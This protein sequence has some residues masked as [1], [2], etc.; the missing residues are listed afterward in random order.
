MA[1]LGNSIKHSFEK[2]T[3]SSTALG[4]LMSTFTTVAPMFFII[5]GI[6]F[7]YRIL[8][9]SS[10]IYSQRVLFSCSIL[11][12]FI[13]SLL[14]TAP[15]N[16]VISRY[17]T[18]RIFEE[19]YD[20]ILP[21]FYGGLFLNLTV[22]CLFGIP[23]GLLIGWNKRC[24][25]FLKPIFELIRPVPALAWIPLMT[26]WFGIGESSKIALIFIGTLMPVVVNTYSGVRLIPRLNIDVARAFG[27][28]EFQIVKEIVL[29]CSLSAIMAGVKTAMGTAWI[30]VL[31]AEMI[32]ANSGLGFMII[33]GSDV[34]DL[35][36]VILAMIII[37]VIGAVLSWLLTLAERKLCPWKEEIN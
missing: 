20:A 23:F 32:S 24:C 27:A 18:D 26:L 31:A 4:V 12:I 13:F 36:L 1:S 6:L 3:I 28:T 8:D 34:A 33:R 19:K 37:G 15:F 10:V 17:I 7:L 11:Y 16:S 29:P 5:G 30:V 21:C 2:K 14:C 35:S 9:Y 22:C 25:D